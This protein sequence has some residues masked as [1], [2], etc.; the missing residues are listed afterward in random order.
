MDGLPDE[1]SDPVAGKG[2]EDDEPD[3][4]G[5]GT[6]TLAIEAQGLIAGRRLEA[7]VDRDEGDREP[8]AESCGNQPTDQRDCENAPV[9]T[10][11]V[12]DRLQHE[13]GEWDTWYPRDEAND[14]EDG[15]DE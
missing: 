12:H 5:I 14:V 3:Q 9:M 13:D 4:R 2:D 1:L 10:S 7:N 15:Q 8:S 6:G 11:D